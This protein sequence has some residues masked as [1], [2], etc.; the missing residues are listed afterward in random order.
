MV[1]VRER[2]VSVAQNNKDLVP[3]RPLKADTGAMLHLESGKFGHVL[4]FKPVRK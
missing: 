3:G 4:L 1:R 2:K